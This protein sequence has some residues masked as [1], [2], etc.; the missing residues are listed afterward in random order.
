[1][2]GSPDGSGG[3]EP[4]VVGGLEGRAGQA[5]DAG[6]VIKT[7]APG[8]VGAKRWTDQFGAA[9]LCV[10]YREN[11]GCGRR[12]TTVELLVDER[13]M[14]TPVAAKRVEQIAPDQTLGVR[15]LAHERDLR[16]AVKQ[17][18]ARWDPQACLW[19]VAASQVQRLGLTDRVVEH[20]VR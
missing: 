7:I 6:R 18:G 20:G 16:H 17:A 15:I 13:I 3:H 2:N 12:Y 8:Q 5:L 1:M 4:W 11:T 19:F 9:L 10:R 14:S